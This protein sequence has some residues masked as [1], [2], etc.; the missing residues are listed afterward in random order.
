VGE[1]LHDISPSLQFEVALAAVLLPN[2]LP[3]RHESGLY[4]QC[5][6]ILHTDLSS[7]STVRLSPL[8]DPG[9]YGWP[10][11]SASSPRR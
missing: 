5:I 6:F 2:A 11:R 7:V 10:D 1:I 3:K 9:N 8:R 4:Y